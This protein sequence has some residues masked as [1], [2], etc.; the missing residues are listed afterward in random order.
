MHECLS[1]KFCGVKH[2]ANILLTKCLATHKTPLFM[3]PVAFPIA[4]FK[5]KLQFVFAY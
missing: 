4:Y 1:V 2:Y 3:I 5:L